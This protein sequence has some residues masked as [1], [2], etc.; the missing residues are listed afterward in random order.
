MA[1]HACARYLYLVC[2][3]I[4][5]PLCP[6]TSFMHLSALWHHLQVPFCPVTS[7]TGNVKSFM[8]I[9]SSS[10]K[11]RY[12]IVIIITLFKVTKT[13]LTLYS[14]FKAASHIQLHNTAHINRYALYGSVKFSLIRQLLS[15][16]HGQALNDEYTWSGYHLG[17]IFSRRNDPP[18]WKSTLGYYRI[19]LWPYWTMGNPIQRWTYKDMVVYL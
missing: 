13:V 15:H 5:A 8:H 11:L 7:F 17:P 1:S 12:L 3:V 18:L 19:W 10:I 4:Y 2:D 14:L 9:K 6:V 16:Y